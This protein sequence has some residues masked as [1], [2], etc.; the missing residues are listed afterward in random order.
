MNKFKS[1]NATK[2]ELNAYFMGRTVKHARL[3]NTITTNLLLLPFPSNGLGHM[4]YM[5]NIDVN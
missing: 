1:Y 4:Y 5:N 3:H 2:H